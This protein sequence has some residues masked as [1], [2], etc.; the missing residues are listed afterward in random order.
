MSDRP[1]SGPGRPSDWREIEPGQ[2]RGQGRLRVYV[3]LVLLTV[4]GCPAVTDGL[5][6]DFARLQEWPRREDGPVRV[7][8]AGFTAP[9]LVRRVPWDYAPRPPPWATALRRA[10]AAGAA[11]SLA[12][13]SRPPS[14]GT[15]LSRRAAYA[16][17]RRQAR[18]A[19]R[20]PLKT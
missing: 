7:G 13:A 4:T 12:G 19:L 1:T 11:S 16:V 10:A 15:L 9:S 8:G 14:A 18:G 5:D 17:T 20:A 2:D 6:G 3:H